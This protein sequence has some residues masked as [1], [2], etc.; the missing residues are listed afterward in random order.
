MSNLPEFIKRIEVSSFGEES[1]LLTQ[2]AQYNFQYT[3]S[4][5]VSLTMKPQ[6]APYNTGSIHPVFAQNLPEGYVRKFI[7]EK[8]ERHAKVNDLYLLALQQ[9]RGIGHLAF[10]SEIQ[11]DLNEQLSLSDILSWKGESSVFP[12]LLNKYYL[13]GFASGVQ[14]KVLL[15]NVKVTA[16]QEHLIV[17]SFDEEYPLLTVNEYVCMKAAEAAGLSPPNCWLSEDLKT[18]VIERFDYQDG[19]KLGFEDFSVLTGQDKYRGSYEMLLK[20]IEIYTKSPDETQKGYEYIVFNCLIGNGDAHLKNFA[21]QY[22]KER[23]SIT[24][25]PPYDITHTLIYPIIDKKMALKMAGAKSFPNKDALIK[26]GKTAKIK[27]AEEIIERVADSIS[28]YTKDSDKISLIKEL[29][30]SIESA[31][32][33]ACSSTVSKATYRHDKRRKYDSNNKSG[34]AK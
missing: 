22:T 17:K 4:Q 28:D 2:P 5:A 25:T 1:G 16:A 8:L 27:G 24:L 6:D 13:G 18:F 29:K 12:E 33:M 20:A 26:L 31:L 19:D 10:N 14:P 34:L 9:G 32:S 15:S 30:G 7:S 11:T 3:G 21:V 23:D